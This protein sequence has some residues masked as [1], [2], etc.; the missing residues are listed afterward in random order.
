M[1]A[2]RSTQQR[3]QDAKTKLAQGGDAWLAT[4]GQAEPHLV[5][6]TFVWDQQNEVIIFCTEPKHRT[7]GNIEKHPAVRVAFGSTRDVL[8]VYGSAEIIGAVNDDEQTA[9][10]FSSQ[11]GWDPRQS[12][13][14]WIFI[15][16]I[17]DRMQAWREVNEI[18][19]RT[20][21]RNGQWVADA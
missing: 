3:I 12:S 4:A 6:L 5:P 7:A 13:G 18:Q 19:G 9:A 17:P 14:D 16:I 1:N 20:I 8:L 21:M 11:T 2:A 10:L 15:R